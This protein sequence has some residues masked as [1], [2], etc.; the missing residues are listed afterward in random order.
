MPRF[1]NIVNS[2][3]GEW[4]VL[5]KAGHN[6]SGAL[7]WK[8]SC[9]C[10][11]IAFRTKN[12]LKHSN[13]CGCKTKE[14]MSLARKGKPS[15]A[16]KAYGVA[17][18]NMLRRRYIFRSQ[19]KGIEYNLS[20]EFLKETFAKDCHYCGQSPQSVMRSKEIYGDYIYNGLDRVD[21]LG[22]YTEDNVVPCCTRCNQMKSSITQKEFFD[23]IEAIYVRRDRWWPVL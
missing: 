12:N 6:K 14:R 5:E 3:F 10:G 21:S 23:K 11:T 9:T 16:R 17:A 13:S 1:I 19:E 7:L 22:G 2:K 20:D 4:T 18:F 8:V 15:T